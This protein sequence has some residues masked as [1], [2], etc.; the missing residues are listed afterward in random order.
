V[1][2][3]F[4]AGTWTVSANG[5]GRLRLVKDGAVRRVAGGK[6]FRPGTAP[7]VLSGNRYRGTITLRLGGSRV[8]ALNTVGIDAYVRGVVPREMLSGWHLEAYKAQAVAARSYSLAGAGHC[9]WFG[10]SVLCPTT[11]DQ[12]YGGMAAET[13]PTN[14]AV[15]ETSREVIVFGSQV[16]SAFF[17]SSSGGR[18]ASV[19]DEWG[20]TGFPYLVS[21]A[22][23]HDVDS[24][25]HNWGPDA[26]EDCPNAGKDC[27]WSSSALKREFGRRAPITDFRVTNRNGSRRVETARIYGPH[28]STPFTG[29]AVR[30]TLGLRSTWFTIGVLRLTGATTIAQGKRARLHA[31]VRNLGGAKLQRKIGAGPWTDM[32]DLHGQVDVRVRPGATTLYRIAS[33]AAATAPVRVG[34]VS[35]PRF[36]A[37]RSAQALTGVASPGEAVQV[38]RLGAR[39][40]WVTVAVALARADGTWRAGFP[41]APGTY[42]AYVGLAGIVGTSP[43]LTLVAP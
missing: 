32:R 21:V 1:A 25:H 38:Q 22:D 17:S 20:S 29:A 11:S 19:Q 7:L 33:P 16:A 14:T 23:P 37:S 31:L 24:P 28:S 18:T 34:V 42:R 10:R 3:P 2:Q 30:S 13:T 40:D 4:A 12:V 8:W 5:D 39:G 9:K 26:F 6:L 35:Q 15:A 27:V 36:T 41:V 43:E